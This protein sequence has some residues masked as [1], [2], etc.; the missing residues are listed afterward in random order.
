[1]HKVLVIDDEENIR[2]V[3]SEL[4]SMRGFSV[5]QASDGPSGIREF[6]RFRPHAV[7]LDHRMPGM[8]G[9]E[10]LRALKEID[11]AV[12]VI[13]LT[14][15]ADIQAAVEAIKNG[16]HDFVTKPADMES[17]AVLIR[18]AIEKLELEREV[19]RLK[20]AVDASLEAALGRGEAIRRV[21]SQLVRV[22]A[23]DFAIIIQGETGTG[24]S[25][26]AGLV[27]RMSRRKEGP[28]V[29]VD[30][31]AIPEPLI[32]SE[33]FGFEKGAFTGADRARG[34][35]FEA[36]SGGTLF[37]D[38]LEN[39][40]AALQSKLLGA[41]ESKQVCRVGSS[42][43]LPVDVR[44]LA[45]SNKD[46]R[47]LV[48]EGS[49]REDLYF[50]LNEFTVTLPPLRERA[51]DISFLA[52]RFL[53][54][55]CEELK[56]PPLSVSGPAMEALLSHP[57][58]GNI[59]ELKNVMRRAALLAGGGEVHPTHLG[60]AAGE[61][62]DRLAGEVLPLKEVSSHAAREAERAAIREALKLSSGN[63]ARTASILKIDY[64]TLLTKI[65]AY[66]LG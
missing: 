22:A 27:H 62:Y 26:I 12:P 51:D 18:K 44:I 66:D 31:G 39:T 9:F 6:G 46:L 19:V 58:S 21:I 36:A 64:K 20:T 57:W 29:R 5:S 52:G 14:A 30:M 13:F 59:R 33:L 23:S 10:T 35:Y 60:F 11:P 55:A 7:L 45:A 4:L 25:M 16:A 50:R 56:R 3:L 37:I 34:G 49:F 15:Y 63:K 8:G 53:A 48:K 1:M 65:R 32:E 28:F 38:E 47:A 41:V 2:L 24:K 61:N 54:D 43:P 17:L 42:K 40:S